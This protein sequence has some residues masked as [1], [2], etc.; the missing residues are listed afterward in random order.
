MGKAKKVDKKPA[1]VVA[2]KQPKKVKKYL[3]KVITP[4]LYDGKFG[5]YMAAHM[6]D[7]LVLKENGKPYEFKYLGEWV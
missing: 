2:T 6:D 1:K 3:G 7:K 5:K 4:V